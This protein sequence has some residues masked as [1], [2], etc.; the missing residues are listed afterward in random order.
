[1]NALD[2]MKY[3]NR[4]LM[5]GL[6]GLDQRYW[7]RPNVCGVWSVKDILAHLTSYELVLVEMLEWVLDESKPLA[8][9]QR[10]ADGQKFNDTEVAK[11]K[12]TPPDQVLSEYQDAH[13]RVMEL[14]SQVP[15]EKRRQ[16]GAI[17]W[18]GLEYDL[19]DMLAYM[20]YG[21]KREHTAQIN[22]FKDVLK[23]EGKPVA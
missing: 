2:V 7:D 16:T 12:G 14:L 8:T 1:M 5:S 18:Y 9:L 11:R 20:F 19:E 21:H 17:P 6:D 23:A 22:V 15:E 4:T 3:G 10:M 13:T